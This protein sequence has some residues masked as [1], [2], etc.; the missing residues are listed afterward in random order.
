[1]VDVDGDGTGDEEQRGGGGAGPGQGAY[2]GGGCGLNGGGAGVAVGGLGGTLTSGYAPFLGADSDDFGAAGGGGYFGGAKGSGPSCDVGGGGGGGSCYLA[3]SVI[4]PL[5]LAATGTIPA[6]DSRPWVRGNAGQGGVGWY[7]AGTGGRVV[8]SWKTGVSC[9]VNNGLCDANATCTESGQGTV[10]CACNSN[11]AG[12][13]SSCVDVTAPPAANL[14]VWVAADRGLVMNGATVASWLDQSGNGND[15]V[16]S[17]Q[18]RQP[19]V[20]PT[21]IGGL[22]AL[23]FNASFA[24]TLTMATNLPAPVTICYVARISGP[25]HQRVLS[26]LYNNWLLGWHGNYM[27]R[28]YFE[29]WVSPMAVSVNSTPVSYCTV[30]SS[31]SSTFSRNGVQLNEAFGGFQG[32]NGLS[33]VGSGGSSEFSD[34]QVAEIL[35]YGAALGGP[36]RAHVET[37]LTSKYGL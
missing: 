16:Q 11:Y 29:G 22:P 26:G 12:D 18:G 35:V 19:I 15:F 20:D 1:M 31:S 23:Q 25:N 21:G 27:D 28:A 14:S 33:V 13:G 17:N 34:A 36:E 4:A 5:Q 6:S 7:E 32:P 2:G 8:I 9:S 30:I 10:T 3:P 37:Y 24:Q